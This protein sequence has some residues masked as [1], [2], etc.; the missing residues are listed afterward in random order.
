MT[1]T[2]GR[3]KKCGSE[4]SETLKPRN[5]ETPQTKRKLVDLTSGKEYAG[6]LAEEAAEGEVSTCQRFNVSHVSQLDDSAEQMHEDGTLSDERLMDE[7]RLVEMD[8][9][10]EREVCAWVLR[11]AQEHG[12][13]TLHFDGWPR[14]GGAFS[15]KKLVFEMEFEQVLALQNTMEQMGWKGV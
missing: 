6:P 14:G 7:E 2:G 5:V 8:S 12:W 15:W 11:A 3:F 10:L 1:S 4:T 9:R 13:K